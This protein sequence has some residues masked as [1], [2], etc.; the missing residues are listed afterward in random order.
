MSP[1]NSVIMRARWIRVHSNEGNDWSNAMT[2]HA[3]IHQG[4]TG[5]AFQVEVPFA[6]GAHVSVLRKARRR[7]AH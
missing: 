7:N 5:E 1:P 2:I 4:R 3:L 6:G